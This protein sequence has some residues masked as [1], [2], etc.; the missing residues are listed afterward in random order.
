MTYTGVCLEDILHTR[1][2]T[3]P[4]V[5]FYV[6]IG[7]DEVSLAEVKV[8]RVAAEQEGVVLDEIECFRTEFTVCAH[9]N[10]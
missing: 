1:D 6:H 9:S 3:A 4:V 7:C 10:G 8:D 2:N 5:L